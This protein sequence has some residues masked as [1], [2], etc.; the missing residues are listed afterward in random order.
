M[1]KVIN[2]T[3]CNL[4]LGEIRDARLRLNISMLCESCETARLALKMK[5]G[6]DKYG[7]GTGFNDLFDGAFGEI[8]GGSAFKK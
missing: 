8:F 2:C 4:Y 6:A 1:A 5:E 3:E 7:S